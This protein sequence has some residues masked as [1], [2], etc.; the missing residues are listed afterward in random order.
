MEL[1]TDRIGHCVETWIA[2]VGKEHL[3]HKEFRL[4]TAFL[5]DS[6]LIFIQIK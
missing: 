3:A 4:C 1:R 2:F 6:K 5:K